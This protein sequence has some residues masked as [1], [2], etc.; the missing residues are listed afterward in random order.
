ME[1]PSSPVE[2]DPLAFTPVPRKRNRADGLNADIQQS[3]IRILAHCGSPRRAAKAVGKAAFGFEQLRRAPGAESFS[4][5]WD[6]AIALFKAEEAR[7]CAINAD[8]VR[9]EAAAWQP[10][11]G[12]FANAASRAHL[13][14][15]AEP[16]EDELEAR[17]EA[18][19]QTFMGICERYVFKL[20]SERRCRLEGR[21]AEADFYVRQAT[22]LEIALD[23][24]GGDAMALLRDYRA[25]GH[26]LLEIAETPVSQILGELR[27]AHFNDCGDPALPEHPP[28]HLLVDQGGFKTVPLYPP[29]PQGMDRNEHERATQ[30]QYAR[31]A[32]AQIEWEAR[33]RREFENRR[34]SAT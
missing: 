33:A 23:M 11:R 12:P 20:Q 8:V 4:A 9:Q 26:S 31:D 16:T 30:E 28:G 18:K 27:R 25:L 15:P 3:F 24:V 34:D 5:A 32:A 14:P 13:Q 17:E 19:W 1:N 22:F 6:A 21:I 10:A 2:D 29:R 7:R